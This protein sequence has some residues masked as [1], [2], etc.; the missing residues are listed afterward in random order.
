MAAIQERK[1]FL[2]RTR[3]LCWTVAVAAASGS[4]ASSTSSF[5]R[6]QGGQVAP[7]V[8]VQVYDEALCI[9]CQEFILNDLV[10]TFE[11]L[12]E[13][14]MDLQI[15]PFGNAQIADENDPTSLQCQHDAAECDANSYQ[16]CAATLYPIA[17]RYLPFIACCYENLEMGHFHQLF[18]TAIFADCARRSALDW[19]S[20]QQCH[21]DNDLAWQLQLDAF[22]ATP[23]DH[24][25][26]PWIVIDGAH[27]EMDD[28]ADAF[29]KA[30]CIA[31]VAKGGHHTACS[32]VMATTVQNVEEIV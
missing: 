11:L 26:V 19:A 3:F 18:P 30:I 16:Q 28:E 22:H 24:E 6:T 4:D 27:Y 12:G 23:A 9:G 29:F 1:S 2:S 15:V 7:V 31:Y 10:P 32:D 20:I 8:S 13:T 21:D 5:L 14:V 17:S 25:Y